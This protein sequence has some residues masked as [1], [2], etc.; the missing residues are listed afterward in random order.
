MKYA[1]VMTTHADWQL[2]KPGCA[3]IERMKRKMKVNYV[4]PVEAETPEQAAENWIDEEL[5]EMGYTPADVTI[6]PCCERPKKEKSETK[7]EKPEPTPMKTEPIIARSTYLNRV[8]QHVGRE[9]TKTERL[10]LQLWRNE[11]FTFSE[12]ITMFDLIY[13]NVQPE[14]DSY[15][16]SED[17]KTERKRATLNGSYDGPIT[18][19]IIALWEK[20]T[21][22]NELA[23]RAGLKRGKFRRELMRALGGQNEYQKKRKEG[24]GGE[25]RTKGSS[26]PSGIDD[27]DVKRIS[28]T[29]YVDG[30][31]SEI[32]YVNV[33]GKALQDSKAGYM[34]LVSESV[35]ISPNGTKYIRAKGNEKADLIF[36]AK[37]DRMDGL[38]DVR[39]KKYEGS[40]KAKKVEE[41]EKLIE[42]GAEAA[43]AKRAEKKAKKSGKHKSATEAI[44]EVAKPKH[45]KRKGAGR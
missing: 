20:K 21:P 16:P 30:W 23:K 12:A 24:A 39:L 34:P 41:H 22:I 43:R 38:D 6:M 14:D 45:V 32:L 19:D 28:K 44:T 7:K 18:L 40:S 9:L 36:R 37:G 27:S 35:F 3:D 25:V 15:L 5:E 4:E 13:E 17:T 10:V 33:G 8:G 1:M 31:R 11:G 29:R 26:L 42:R 2:H